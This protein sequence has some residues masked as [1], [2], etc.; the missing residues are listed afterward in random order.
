MRFYSGLQELIF[1]DNAQ[2]PAKNVKEK[3]QSTERSAA[4]TLHVESF[5]ISTNRRELA[6]DLMSR[7]DY[8]ALLDWFDNV[9]D[10]A[11]NAF[12]FEDEELNVAEVRIITNAYDFQEDTYQSY[13]GK[14]TLEYI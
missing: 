11:K 14:M 1:E 10:G 5:G 12:F 4:G 3:I 8:M 2:Y 6:F 7:A 13:S 9:A